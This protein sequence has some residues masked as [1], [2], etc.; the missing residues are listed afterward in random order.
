MMDKSTY[1]ISKMNCSSEEQLVRI[2]LDGLDFIKEL[3]FDLSNRT[4]VV[5][6]QN[7]SDVIIDKINELNLD[8]TLINY[9]KIDAAHNIQ[10]YKNE[11]KTL[12]IVLT[13]NAGFFLI[14]M[15]FGWISK[16]MGLVADSLDML[17]DASV[18]G[19]SLYAV[20]RTVST[21]KFIAKL[22]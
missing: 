22:S 3:R 7:N 15:V 12:V 1:K 11:K 13:I 18:Y 2:K 14:E 21:K 4:L 6:H 17:A 19:L 10:V 16:S 8:S 5:I 20:G 9:E